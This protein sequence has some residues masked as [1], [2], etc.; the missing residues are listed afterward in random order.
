MPDYPDTKADQMK[1]KAL[2]V[3]T[4]DVSGQCHVAPIRITFKAVPGDT[5]GFLLEPGEAIP[6]RSGQAGFIKPK[7]ALGGIFSIES[8]G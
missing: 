4:E 7:A 1:R 5:A 3:P 2:P 8:I 6:I